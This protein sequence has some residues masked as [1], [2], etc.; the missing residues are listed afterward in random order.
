[1]PGVVL[2][3]VPFLLLV[4]DGGASFTNELTQRTSATRIVLGEDRGVDPRTYSFP[5]RA[6]SLI[7]SPSFRTKSSRHAEEL[8]KDR[9]GVSASSSPPFQG[10]TAS[11]GCICLPSVPPRVP[12]LLGSCFLFD[13]KELPFQM[14]LERET[15]G[16]RSRTSPRTSSQT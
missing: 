2:Y 10:A 7:L 9:R 15:K 13:W 16:R 1:M 14:C 6:Y 8:P 5:S 12:V 4:A 3:L 11:R